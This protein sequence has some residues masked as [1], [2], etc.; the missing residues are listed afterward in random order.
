MAVS[1]VAKISS[2]G[3]RCIINIPKSKIKDLE[4]FIGKDIK[5]SVDMV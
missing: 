2:Q 4:K 5:V 1:F 3:E